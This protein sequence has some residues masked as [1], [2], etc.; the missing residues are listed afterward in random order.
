MRR[1]QRSPPLLLLLAAVAPAFA[2]VV[3]TFPDRG[4]GYP[5]GTIT[6]TNQPNNPNGATITTNLQNLEGTGNKWHVHSGPTAETGGIDAG[7]GAG[8]T[9][10]HYDP[11]FQ[12]YPNGYPNEGDTPVYE[13]G[14]LSG[15]HGLLGVGSTVDVSTHTDPILRVDADFGLPN[16]ASYYSVLGRSIVIHRNDGSRWACANIGPGGRYAKAAFSTPDGPTGSIELF[17]PSELR[18]TAISVNIKSSVPGDDPTGAGFKWHVHVAPV[19]PGTEDCA[20]TGGHFNPTWASSTCVPGAPCEA[21]D[22]SGK[23][24][25]LNATTATI[26]NDATGVP[27]NPPNTQECLIYDRNPDLLPVPCFTDGR[28]YVVDD[29]GLTLYG[30]QS[31]R[32]RSIVIHRADGSRWAC[33]TIPPVGAMSYSVA[34]PSGIGSQIAENNL[35]YGTVDLFQL[36][37]RTPTTVTVSLDGLEAGDNP[38][39]IHELPVPNRAAEMES[40]MAGGGMMAAD[41]FDAGYADGDCGGTAGHF[42]PTFGIGVTEYGD[43]SAKIQDLNTSSARIF[44]EDATLFLTGKYSVV[45]RSI[46]IHRTSKARWACSNIGPAGRGYALTFADRGIEYPKGKFLFFQRSPE[47]PVTLTVDLK[48][49]PPAPGSGY[50]LHE[51]AVPDANEDAETDA[52][53]SQCA[54]DSVGPTFNPAGVPDTAAEPAAGSFDKRFGNLIGVGADDA[55]QVYE[56]TPDL[57]L[58]ADGAGALYGRSVVIY[59]PAAEGTPAGERGLPWACTSLGTTAN[60]TIQQL[61]WYASQLGADVMDLTIVWCRTAGMPLAGVA[62]GFIV[63]IWTIFLIPSI[64]QSLVVGYVWTY[65]FG[66]TAGVPAGALAMWIGSSLGAL[67]AYAIGKAVLGTYFGERRDPRTYMAK[68]EDAMNETPI[69]LIILL[70]LWPLMPFFLFN[71]YVG[72]SYRFRGWHNAVSLLFTIPSCFIWTGIGGAWIKYNLITWRLVAQ[73]DYWSWIWAGIAVTIVLVFFPSVIIFLI[74]GR[75]IKKTKVPSEVAL[76]STGEVVVDVAGEN[77]NGKKKKMGGLFGKKKKGGDAAA[78][79]PPPAGPPPAALQPGWR[80]ITG[81]D[82]DNYFFND[83]T[84]ESQWDPPL[85]EAAGS[86]VGV[87]APPPPGP[88]PGDDEPPPP[89]IAPPPA[90]GGP[91]SAASLAMSGGGD[92]MAE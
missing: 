41:M 19:P 32:G 30:A 42:N 91:T 79:P 63:A 2:Q 48:N 46:V 81:D 10:G 8:V 62:T 72:A 66:G 34:F 28:G 57:D 68:A 78:G 90:I 77:G 29:K 52:M 24:G 5:K 39:H 89:S 38:W 55:A 67:I 54:A 70:R 73:A 53:A 15:K 36:D 7:C 27:P 61:E 69:R 65:S 58:Y 9:G 44:A 20:A 45:G 49:M 80:E 43:L 74:F 82:G 3:V 33:A 71:Y 50:A 31:V 22:L 26:G 18:G 6:I 17:Q 25:R 21:G 60:T 4:V 59:K 85:L 13:I 37:E 47:E 23:W 1:C 16:T 56:E 76:T 84:G 88:P 83:E 87:V 75:A 11:T 14:D 12:N 40:A 64:L 92:M 35:P 86:T 51:M